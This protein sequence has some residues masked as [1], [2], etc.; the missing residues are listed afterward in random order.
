[1]SN[2]LVEVEPDRVTKHTK[3]LTHTADGIASLY[4]QLRAKPNFRALVTVYFDRIQELENALWDLLSDTL[5][6]AIGAQLDQ[7][8]ALLNFGRGEVSDDEEYRLFLRAAILAHRSTGTANDVQR[9]ARLVFGDDSTF[10]YFEG[11]A[12]ILIDPHAVIT[13]TVRMIARLLG[14][15]KAGGVQLHLIDPPRVESELF[16]FSSDPFRTETSS[17]LGFGDELNTT[18]G[19]FTGVV[20]ASAS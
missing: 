4:M 11:H 5:E 19:Y 16:T 13:V 12:S 3:I 20:V 15:T 7:I 17:T 18:G 14:M 1:M 8:G 10:E 6:T 9:V 2:P